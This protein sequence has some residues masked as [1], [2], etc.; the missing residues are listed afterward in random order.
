MLATCCILALASE[1]G[2]KLYFF[3]VHDSPR[4]ILIPSDNPVLIYELEPNARSTSTYMNPERTD[5]R[6]T[7]RINERGFRGPAPAPGSGRPSILVLGDSI[8]FGYGV[9]DAQTF[10]RR[11]AELFED[12]VDVLN[13][14]VPG[15]NLIQQVESLRTRGADYAPDVVILAFHPNDFEPPIFAD[16]GRVRMARWSHVYSLYCF[17]RSAYGEDDAA[18]LD[19]TREARVRGAN[20][21]FEELLRM[22]E[23]RGFQLVVFRTDCW[24]GPDA[25]AARQFMERSRGRGLMTIDLDAD[26]CKQ[27]EL[28]SIPDDGHPTVEGH[29]LLASRLFAHLPQWSEHE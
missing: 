11:L 20:K 1:L 12:R 25:N 22:S 13:F 2:V 26:L 5:W 16:A 4:D 3:G 23:A 17:V 19:R 29:A 8:A 14:G 7:I 28:H 24:G 18:M 10:P 6:H 21:A 27:L 15:Y 9:D